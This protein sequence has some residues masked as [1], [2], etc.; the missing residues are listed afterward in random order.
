MD[1]KPKIF[2]AKI[3]LFEQQPLQEGVEDC[4][5]VAPTVAGYRT[6]ITIE[7][8]SHRDPPLLSVTFLDPMMFGDNTVRFQ[9][10][11]PDTEYSKLKESTIFRVREGRKEVAIGII[12]KEETANEN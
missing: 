10:V 12:V 4:G 1:F 6:N 7:P 5:R 3:K 2:I 8:S 9:T 11:H